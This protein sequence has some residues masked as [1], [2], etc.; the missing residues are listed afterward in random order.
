MVLRNAHDEIIFTACRQLF[1][2][3]NGLDAELEACKEGLALALVRTTCPIQV[4]LDCSEAVVMLQATEQNR[5]RHMTIVSELQGMLKVDRE[6]SVTLTSRTKN[7]VSHSL[8]A[9]R[10]CTPQTAVWL[11]GGIDEIVNLCKDGEPP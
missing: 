1:A 7:K 4:E 2:C 8:A 5:S 3:D 9:Y 6:I 11:G 10:H